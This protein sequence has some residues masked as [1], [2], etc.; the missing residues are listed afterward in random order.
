MI[1]LNLQTAF[2]T[3]PVGFALFYMRA[4]APPSITTGDIY[5]GIVPFVGLQTLA[6]A[7]L[8]LAPQAA[9]W[10]PKMIFRDAV[11][12]AAGPGP[13]SVLDD[14]LQGVTGASPRP[15]G[16]PLDQLLDQPQTGQPPQGDPILDRLLRGN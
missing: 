9:T 14:I 5:R 7:A 2:L 15:S 10:L 12:A 16:S 3:P 8:W 13:G 1:G 11:P 6:I 4:V